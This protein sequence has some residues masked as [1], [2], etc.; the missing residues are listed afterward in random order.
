LVLADDLQL[1][2]Q[3]LRRLVPNLTVAARSV[4][5]RSATVSDLCN[6]KIPLGRAEVRTLVA[7]ADLAGCTLDDLVIRG[8]GSTM[9][10][11]GIKVI[12]LFAPLVRGGTVGLVARTGMGQMVVL[13]ELLHRLRQRGYGTVLWLP[14]EFHPDLQDVLPEAE[15]VAHSLAAAEEQV[16]A[17][18]KD[19]E[20]LVATDRAMVLSGEL[21]ELRARLAGGAGHAVTFAL[22]DPR[23]ESPD[24]EVPYGPLET[25]WRFDADLAARSV[26][27]AIDPVGSTSIILEGAYADQTHMTLQQRARRLYRRY[28]ELH[29]LARVRGIER[30]PDAEVLTYRRG[31]RLE[32][33]LK[34]PFYVTE[35]WVRQP[36]EWVAPA[37][38]IEAARRILDGPGE[39][40]HPAR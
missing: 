15:V 13:S 28:R 17:W 35:P 38:G 5:L 6:G 39:E 1:N 22:V 30:I 19:R 21:D 2:V 33:F 31:E 11:T 4:G 20:V 36:G 10:E 26:F 18:Q 12:D 7:L 37:D 32:A 40:P 9:V 25:L 34:Q 16:K 14:A 8:P 29:A 24:E 3:L 23:G 27:P